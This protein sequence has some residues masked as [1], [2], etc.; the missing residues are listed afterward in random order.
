MKVK[1]LQRKNPD[2]QLHALVNSGVFK[3]Y[4]EVR[5][6]NKAVIKLYKEG[7]LMSVFKRHR[8]IICKG[9]FVSSVF[10]PIALHL[11]RG[12]QP[13]PSLRFKW[14]SQLP[15]KGTY[16]LAIW[17]KELDKTAGH[18]IAFKNGHVLDSHY[19]IGIPLEYYGNHRIQ[20]GSCFKVA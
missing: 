17:N 10:L 13:V 4:R 6:L 18:A 7:L 16:L 3:S 1:S 5:K 14:L 12:R 19:K 2:C 9:F 11:K 15:K 20:Y 8:S